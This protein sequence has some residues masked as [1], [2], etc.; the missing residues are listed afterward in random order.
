MFFFNKI[1]KKFQQNITVININF[2]TKKVKYNVDF[3]CF[4]I[5]P[6]FLLKY[7]IILKAN[8]YHGINSIAYL[9][10]TIQQYNIVRYCK[11][12]TYVMIKI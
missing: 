3:Q 2:G 10:S 1:N 8:T 12:T 11:S 5:L 6:I 4:M 9:I 7:T